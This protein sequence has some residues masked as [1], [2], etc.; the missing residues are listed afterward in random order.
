MVL[1]PTLGPCAK[2]ARGIS[3]HGDRR[4]DTRSYVTAS[5]SYFADVLSTSAHVGIVSAARAARSNH[6]RWHYKSLSLSLPIYG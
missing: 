3:S 5:P 4:A 1:R 6:I 2:L